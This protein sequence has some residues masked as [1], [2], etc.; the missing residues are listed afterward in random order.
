MKTTS[1][2]YN[3]R[4]G[5][6]ICLSIIVVVECRLVGYNLLIYKKSLSNVDFQVK[7]VKFDNE[8]TKYIRRANRKRMRKWRA[9]LY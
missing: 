4:R 6:E 2:H 5:S 7:K 9:P 1:T 8:N 3:I